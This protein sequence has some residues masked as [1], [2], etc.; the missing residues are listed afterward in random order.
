MSGRVS[1]FSRLDVTEGEVIR[2]ANPDDPR[3]ASLALYGYLSWLE[4]Q[5]V[6]AL[7]D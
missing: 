3:A 5:L 6:E 2:R 1:V 4:E 7:S